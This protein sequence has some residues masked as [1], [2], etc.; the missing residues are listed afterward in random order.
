[1]TPASATAQ[2]D[3]IVRSQD[4]V[5]ARL[6][7]EAYA[8][9]R[10]YRSVA[11]LALEADA[12]TLE[13]LAA[14]PEVARIEEDLRHD[15]TLAQS[16]PL[17]GAPAAWTAGYTGAGQAVAVLDTGVER[18]H[19]FLAGKVI[20]EACFSTTS[21]QDGTTSACPNG[22]ST[23]TGTGA[24]TPCSGQG[25]DHGTHC[26]GI[27]AGKGNSF[28]GV[29]KEAKIVAVQVFSNTSNGGATSFTSDDVAALDWVYQQRN[30]F[31]TPVS[32]INMSLGGG[33]FYGACDG[34]SPAMKQAVDNLRSAGIATVIASGNNGWTDSIS[35]PACISSAVAVG[36]TTKS[37]QVSDFSNAASMLK[38]LAPGSDINSSV[39]G[40]VFGVKSGT[41]MATPHVAGAWAVLKSKKPS[42]SVDEVL[43]AF[44]STG[45]SIT[46]W[47]GNALARP[48]IRVDQA[49]AA[50]SGGGG[51]GGG[52][53]VAQH[54]WAA[55][56]S[57]QVKVRARCAVTQTVVSDWSAPL[58][59]SITQ[60][61]ETVSAPTALSG[62]LTGDP[63]QSLTYTTG[64]SASSQG[65]PV[66]YY[67]DWLDG[68]NSGWL[69]AGTTSASHAW[70]GAGTFGVRTKARSSTNTAIESGWSATLPVSV[71]LTTGPDL[72]GSWSGAKQTCKT[73]KGVTNCTITGKYTVTNNGTVN[74]GSTQ[75]WVIL[76]TDNAPSED[77][78]LIKTFSVTPLKPRAKKALKLSFKLP[79]GYTAAGLY[80]MGYIDPSNTVAETN[81]SNNLAN[82]GVM[83]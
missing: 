43:A 71:R 65:N 54:A 44:S 41:S 63:G 67:F 25:C 64:G 9:H 76:S 68:T 49:A 29:A 7:G 83:R 28:S 35:H 74:S 6:D 50:L 77:D 5:L 75:A 22:Q 45:V 2:Q 34:D 27:S 82:G 52:D 69:P 8:L 79:T 1:M 20:A 42:A 66:Q 10:R 17:V 36:S 48:R 51:G 58:D 81:E 60:A 53:A 37:D 23:Q 31:G 11:A 55:G 78:A 32:S 72:V 80:L 46:D 14:S 62:P 57:Y 24:A 18:T 12:R 21:A 30:S 73:K 4:A 33:Q 16:G 47:R 26:A 15:V 61:A 3:R 13:R 38:L 59:V 19:P 70:S 39:T 56:A 40:G